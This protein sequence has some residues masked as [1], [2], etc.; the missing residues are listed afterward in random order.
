MSAWPKNPSIYEIDTWS[1]LSALGASL[2]TPVGLHSVPAREWDR[3]AGIGVHAVWLRGVWERSVASAS[4]ADRMALE[5]GEYRGAAPDC[6]PRDSVGSTLCVRRYAVDAGLGGAPGLMAARR[7]LRKRGLRLVLD[8]VPNHVAPDHPWVREHPEYF[9]RGT[10]AE[11][12][13]D[14]RSYIRRHGWVFACGR[15]AYFPACPF[16]LQL[17]AF[18]P[19]L[20]GEVRSTLVDIAAQCDGVRCDLAMVVMNSVFART[21]GARA[22]T[23]PALEYWSD[24]I[25]AVR[26]IH[27]GCLFIADAQ[28]EFAAELQRQGFDWAYDGRLYDHLVHGEM[29]VVNHHLPFFRRSETESVS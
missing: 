14:P 3:L 18:N 10:P 4:I 12:L 2:G 15:D 7:E 16:V 26:R 13:R 29:H 25:P 20:R 8:F 27:P 6:Q 21:W 28:W 22:G 5:R 9:I 1:W 11:A 24:V 17:N 23:K 19:W